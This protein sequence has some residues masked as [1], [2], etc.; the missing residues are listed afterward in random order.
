MVER[1]RVYVAAGGRLL[2]SGATA[3]ERFGR[4]VLGAGVRAVRGSGVFHVPSGDGAV[5]VWSTSWALVETD[6]GRGL[7]ALGETPSRE[8][9]LLPHPA[10][11][12]NRVGRGRVAW[13]P[14]DVFRDFERNRYPMLREFIRS[15]ADALSARAE[16]R[17]AA[18]PCV[19]AVLRRKGGRRI[20]HL[21]NRASGIPTL[22]NSG[23]VDGIPP[24]G[25]VTITVR[26]PDLPR[27]ARLAFEAGDL[28][29][30]RHGRA[31]AAWIRVEVQRIGIHAAVVLE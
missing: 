12:L 25:P 14:F 23:A 29:V 26:G 3:L 18:P 9:R 17:V 21:V 8:E 1:L 31:S 19:D 28:S 10:A 24:V 5:A 15:V 20:V 30:E 11:V 27:S 16:I 6:N 4:D 22:P 2:V 13:I 7:G